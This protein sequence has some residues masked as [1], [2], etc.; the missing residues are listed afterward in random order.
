MRLGGPWLRPRGG[1]RAMNRRSRRR[2]K[3][4]EI[5]VKDGGSFELKGEMAEGL[6]IANKI[7]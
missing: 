2:T 5:T 1:P 6:E 3:T 4:A 7:L